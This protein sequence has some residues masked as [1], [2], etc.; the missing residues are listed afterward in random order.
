VA[1]SGLWLLAACGAPAPRPTPA[2]RPQRVAQ[3]ELEAGADCFAGAAEPARIAAAAAPPRSA[4]PRPP[5]T[6]DAARFAAP[7]RLT[8]RA[9]APAPSSEPRP[10]TLLLTASGAGGESR[11]IRLETDSAGCRFEPELAGLTCFEAGAWVEF[12]LA[13]RG[14]AVYVSRRVGDEAEPEPGPSSPYAE[15]RLPDAAPVTLIEVSGA[16]AGA[17]GR[18]TVQAVQERGL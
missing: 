6:V 2:P 18:C 3:P 10:A 13:Q 16:L 17:E 11:T 1:A 5:I 14:A 8:L 15:I 4:A 7:L 9:L 12:T